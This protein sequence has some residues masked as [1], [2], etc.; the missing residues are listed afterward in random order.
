MKSSPVLP[1]LSLLVVAF[2]ACTAPPQERAVDSAAGEQADLDALQKA[3]NDLL[4]AVN[5]DDLNVF[6][7]GVTDDVVLMPPERPTLAGKE[8]IR[9][10]AAEEFGERASDEDWFEDEFVV[11]GDWGFV[12]GNYAATV[13]TESGET[14]ERSGKQL[15]V[16]KRAEDGTWKLARAIWNVTQRVTEVEETIGTIE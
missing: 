7:D 2:A 3:A 11:S 1:F 4:R 15:L 14:E 13:E 5:N 6:L 9:A 16:F 8:M 10:Q 12:R